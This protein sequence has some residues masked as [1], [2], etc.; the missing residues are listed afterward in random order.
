M[1]LAAS[2]RRLPG[3]TRYPTI[4]QV[5]QGPSWANYRRTKRRA[6]AAAQAPVPKSLH[7]CRS[8]GDDKMLNS[9]TTREYENW[10]DAE[11]EN[12]AQW[13]EQERDIAEIAD[14]FPELARYMRAAQVSAEVW[15]H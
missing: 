4:A 12:Q 3:Y 11:T 9:A 13:W 7:G 14:Q 1:P 15:L 5:P 8:L 6:C 10:A 2:G